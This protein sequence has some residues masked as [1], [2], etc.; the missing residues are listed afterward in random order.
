MQLHQGLTVTALYHWVQWTAAGGEYGR[1]LKTCWYR[2]LS[3]L[4]LSACRDWSSWEPAPE[5]PSS[6]GLGTHPHFRDRKRNVFP[7]LHW[8]SLTTTTRQPHHR[9]QTPLGRS[10]SCWVE[11]AW[12]SQRSL[13]WD[14]EHMDGTVSHAS[15]QFGQVV[16]TQT[17]SSPKGIR[18]GGAL[19]RIM[20]TWIFKLKQMTPCQYVLQHWLKLTL[21]KGKPHFY[22]DL[23]NR[24]FDKSCLENQ[25]QVFYTWL[26]GCVY[27]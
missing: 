3:Q 10:G 24:L 25:L 20:T 26:F 1:T 4:W 19:N 21:Y 6:T 14:P 15:C 17:K 22:R 27:K 2:L 23:L 13:L 8:F 5:H 11:A 9:T 16:A 7:T 12:W 18:P